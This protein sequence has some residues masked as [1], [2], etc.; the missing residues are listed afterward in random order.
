[1]P[2]LAAISCSILI[3]VRVLALIHTLTLILAGQGGVMMGGIPPEALMEKEQAI[4]ELRETNEVRRHGQL[5]AELRADEGPI[6]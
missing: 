5:G 2:N 4:N 6:R 1:M 3:H